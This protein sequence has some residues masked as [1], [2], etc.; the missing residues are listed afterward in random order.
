ML[1]LDKAEWEKKSKGNEREGDGKYGGN[2]DGRERRK[3]GWRRKSGKK[4]QG[5]FFSLPPRSDDPA[6]AYHCHQPKSLK[7]NHHFFGFH[8]DIL[9]D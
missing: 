9:T 8:R 7:C 6:S 1:S 4:E 5:D 3:E 2:K